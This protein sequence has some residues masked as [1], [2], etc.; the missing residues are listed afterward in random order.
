[1]GRKRNKKRL[2]RVKDEIPIVSVLATYGYHVRTDGGDREQQFPC[3]L[4][5]DGQDNKPSARV[6]PQSNSWYCFGCRLTRDTVQTV[7]DKE[8]LGFLDAVAYLEKKY[9]LPPLPWEEDDGEDQ[10]EQVAILSHQGKTFEDD[11][12]RFRTFLDPITRERTL[13]M[14]STLTYWEGFDKL[15]YMVAMDMLKEDTGRQALN[16]LRLRLIEAVKE[17]YAVALG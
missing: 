8:D 10:D 14:R 13:P 17:E 5:G 9:H 12:N 2:A 1:M 11:C 4:H 15:V 16:Q 6:Y 7:R 3:D